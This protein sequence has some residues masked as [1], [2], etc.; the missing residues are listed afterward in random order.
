MS[1]EASNTPFA[2]VVRQGQ[3]HSS[4]VTPIHTLLFPMIADSP[5][6]L[7]GSV[8]GVVELKRHTKVFE[9]DDIKLLDVLSQL[10]TPK[11]LIA[12]QAEEEKKRYPSSLS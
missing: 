9:N 3:V 7:Q 12:Y 10:I 4:H 2:E 8:I 1:V 11:L 5:A 6:A